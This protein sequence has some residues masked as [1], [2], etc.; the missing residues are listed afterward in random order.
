MTEKAGSERAG[1]EGG[2][3]DRRL[4]AA[5]A[6]GDDA[7]VEG[8]LAGGADPDVLVTRW[9]R[10]VLVAA[11]S[12]GR[13]DIARRLLDAGASVTRV[14]GFGASPLRAAVTASAPAVVRLLLERGALTTE[15]GVLAQ[16]VG[17][18]THRPAPG[19]LEVLA[20]LLAEG[21]ESGPDEEAALVVAVTASAAPAV[22][23]VLL[24]H[25]ADPD[26]RRSD[27]TPVIVLAARRGDHA[28]LDV[29]VGAGADV[30]AA[31][32]MG[33]TAL[34]HA[35]ER[36]HKKAAGVLLLAGADPGAVSPDGTTASRLA[37]GWG[38]QNIRFRLG[39]DVVGREVAV[40]ERTTL[41][42]RPTGVRIDGDPAMF[43]F[44]ADV[45]AI[46]LGDLG[47]AEWATRTGLSAADAR[48]FAVRLRTDAV[49]AEQGSWF[50]VGASMTELATVRSALVEMAYGTTR[51]TPVG[52]TRVDVE[53]LLRELELRLAG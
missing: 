36:D 8:A 53:D 3:A 46:V 49:A 39:E 7:A 29:L 38:L 2:D 44:L 23:R 30:E 40:I 14:G 15:P 12:A 41:R 33:R 24:A 5:V 20:H 11:A 35:V 52:T 17:R 42:L 43:G 22:L 10:S 34:M 48:A 25:G 27:G 51:T 37:R 19:G 16:A 32:A 45:V 47:D 28:A 6:D 31:D 50:E 21:A 26:R 1:R 18:P 9:R 4:I 13:A